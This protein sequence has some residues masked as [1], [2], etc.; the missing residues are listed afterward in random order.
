MSLFSKK[1]TVVIGGLRLNLH[2][3]NG[4]I[5]KTELY[6]QNFK[7]FESIR[8]DRE[9]IE[10]LE[11]KQNDEVVNL[12]NPLLKK[13]LKEEVIDNQILKISNEMVRYLEKFKDKKNKEAVSKL[14]ETGLLKERDVEDAIRM[15]N[16]P[17][18]L[19]G[20]MYNFTK[21]I[22]TFVSK[23]TKNFRG[24][25]YNKNNYQDSYMD[26]KNGKVEENKA[27]IE[28]KTTNNS[29]VVKEDLIPKQTEVNEQPLDI[30]QE[31]EKNSVNNEL[32]EKVEKIENNIKQLSKTDLEIL[33]ILDSLKPILEDKLKE[34]SGTQ[35]KINSI[36]ETSGERSSKKTSSTKKNQTKEKVEETQKS[37][38]KNSS[39]QTLKDYVAQHIYND[40]FI[41]HNELNP[42]KQCTKDDKKEIDIKQRDLYEEVKNGEKDLKDAKK[43]IYLFAKALVLKKGGI[44]PVV[45]KEKAQ[46]IKA[47][48]VKDSVAPKKNILT[49]EEAANMVNMSDFDETPSCG[50]FYDGFVDVVNNAELGKNVKEFAD[51]ATVKTPTVKG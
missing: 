44:V 27:P 33:T 34:I 3:K 26:A 50:D 15:L 2:V 38:A 5:K 10:F 6:G 28:T 13:Q 36:A 31:K 18:G 7:S 43:E 32:N 14:L 12:D 11:K 35:N 16:R 21:G 39:N 1:R 24:E 20:F 41:K 51:A 23:Y 30:Q 49:E 9:F 45:A 37:P 4:E 40:M 17:I 29:T 8:F 22:A 19:K 47:P 48:I 42:D 25:V 46:E